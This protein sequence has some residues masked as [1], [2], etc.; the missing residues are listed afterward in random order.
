ML[1]TEPAVAAS[2]FGDRIDL[3]RKFTADLARRGEELG[4]IGPLEPPRL[5]SR[6]IINS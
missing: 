2:L 4:L 6:H 1:E 3:A 5:W